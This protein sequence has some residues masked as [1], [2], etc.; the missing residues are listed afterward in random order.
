M[1]PR[2][3]FE[4]GQTIWA[5]LTRLRMLLIVADYEVKNMGNQPSRM[6]VYGKPDGTI[7]HLFHT[8]WCAGWQKHVVSR[9]E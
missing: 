7:R 6:D 4:A 2:V 8:V 5:W 9:P 3:A 1:W